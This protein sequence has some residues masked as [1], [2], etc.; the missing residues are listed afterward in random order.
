[1]QMARRMVGYFDTYKQRHFEVP[2]R[3]RQAWFGGGE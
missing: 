2:D 1:M 3:M